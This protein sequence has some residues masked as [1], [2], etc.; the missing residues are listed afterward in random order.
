MKRKSGIKPHV[1]ASLL[2][3]DR[4]LA[5]ATKECRGFL[6]IPDRELDKLCN[7]QTRLLLK[8]FS[9]PAHSLEGLAVKAR[10]FLAEQRLEGLDLKNHGPADI[11]RL[12]LLMAED[13][14]KMAR[15]AG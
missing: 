12:G 9:T 1:D 15:R 10:A 13:I 5:D 6:D 2:A 4:A 7:R 8:V 14:L 11:S 3:L